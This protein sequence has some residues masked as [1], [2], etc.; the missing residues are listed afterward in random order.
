MD[1]PANADGDSPLAGDV[2]S[3]EL[4]AYRGTRAIRRLALTTWVLV[5]AFLTGDVGGPSVGQLVV[6]RQTDGRE[7]MRIDAGNEEEAAL[8]VSHVREQLATLTPEAF[9]KRWDVDPSA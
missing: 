1:Q 5:S 8:L 7:V 6:R 4:A 2:Y 9:R 3:A